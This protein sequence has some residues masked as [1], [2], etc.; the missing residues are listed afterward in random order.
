MKIIVLRTKTLTRSMV[1]SI[2][3]SAVVASATEPPALKHNPFARPS[4]EGFSESGNDASG[5]RQSS[6]E[7]DLVATMVSK[8]SRLA[9]VNGRIVRPGEEVAG[10]LLLRVLEDRAVFLKNRKQ[11]TIYVRSESET[12]DE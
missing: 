10:F 12:A 11:V 6:E 2:L 3:F 7:F 5:R 1:C 8:S 4:T 9:N